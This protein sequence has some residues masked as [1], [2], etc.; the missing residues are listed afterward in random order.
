MPVA[1]RGFV[2]GSYNCECRDGFYFPDLTAKHTA[3][4]GTM[5]EK[6]IADNGGGNGTGR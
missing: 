1:G 5:V 3:F 2:P 6:Y 4:N